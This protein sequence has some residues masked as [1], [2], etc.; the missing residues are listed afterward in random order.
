MLTP[1]TH[2]IV[3]C[4][5]I[6]RVAKNCA[7]SIERNRRA[8]MIPENVDHRWSQQE[9]LTDWYQYV[10][11]KSNAYLHFIPEE[12]VGITNISG[13]PDLKGHSRV[14]GRIKRHYQIH[15]HASVAVIGLGFGDVIHCLATIPY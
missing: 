12:V 4:P 3:P 5:E 13:A 10:S 6:S 15:M 9:D 7:A 1:Y 2:V 8:F 14:W 11:S